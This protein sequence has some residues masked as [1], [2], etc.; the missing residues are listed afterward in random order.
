MAFLLRWR[1]A[2]IAS[3]QP[4]PLR[5]PICALLN[6]DRMTTE[7]GRAV[8]WLKNSTSVRE[9]GFLLLVEFGILGIEILNTAQWNRKLYR[10]ESGIHHLESGIQYLKSG[11]HNEETRIQ[12][13]LGFPYM[14]QMTIWKYNLK[15]YIRPSMCYWSD[16]PSLSFQWCRWSPLEYWTRALLN[17]LYTRPLEIRSIHG[18]LPW[19]RM[20]DL[21]L[22]STRELAAIQSSTKKKKKRN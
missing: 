5:N 3:V 12:Y 9:P 15:T 21:P 4:L 18:S 11:I 8:T 10:L 22:I 13:C 2:N 14:R 19:G 7:W 1:K 17:F 20:K 6:K 16:S